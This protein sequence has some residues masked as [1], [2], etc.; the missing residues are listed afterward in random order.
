MVAGVQTFINYFFDKKEKK[1]PNW[2]VIIYLVISVLLASLTV[3]SGID[4]IPII[5]AISYIMLITVQKEA[6]IRKFSL[7]NAGFWFIYDMII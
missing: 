1:I 5:C 4:V 7:M 3:S 6:T 2:L